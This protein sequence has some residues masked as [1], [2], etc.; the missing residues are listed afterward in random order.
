[1]LTEQEKWDFKVERANELMRQA[2][3]TLPFDH[4]IGCVQWVPLA[5]VQANDWNPNSVAH[6]EMKLLHTSISEDGYTQPVVG[7]LLQ[8]YRIQTPWGEVVL[9]E[10]N[11]PN[12]PRELWIFLE[13]R[14]KS[15]SPIRLV[16]STVTEASTSLEGLAGSGIPSGS[17]RER[18][19]TELSSV[20][21]SRRSGDSEPSAMLGETVPT[22]DSRLCGNGGSDAPGSLSSYLRL[23]FRTSGS[24]SREPSRPSMLYDL[25]HG[26]DGGIQLRSPSSSSTGK[27]SAIENLPR[28]LDEMSR[29]SGPSDMTSDASETVLPESLDIEVSVS[30]ETKVI[31]VDGFH[32]YTTMRVYDDIRATTRGYLPVVVLDKPPADRMAATVR[33][34]RARGKHSVQGMS[35]LVFGMLEEG[36]TDEQIC[37]KLGLEAEELARLKHITGYSKLYADVATYGKV[38][39]T[40]TQLEE[41]AKYAKEHPDEKVPRC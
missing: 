26:A 39:M 17:T 35:S 36:Q 29:P 27:S 16:A 34:N 32:R 20:V 37:N 23:V 8:K 12:L 22:W 11:L 19:T 28:S 10:D 4:P 14:A 5:K 7:V 31:I 25:W 38:F 15:S 2:F 18:T 24:S 40:K 3:E 9:S 30:D 21:G 13:G 33:H 1:M 6:M 41:K